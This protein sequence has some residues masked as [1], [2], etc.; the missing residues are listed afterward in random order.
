MARG[1]I[2]LS[3]EIIHGFTSSLLMRNFDSPQP[4]PHCHLEW[5]DL[6]CQPERKVA[7]AAP[8][9]HAK[10]TAITHSFTLASLLFRFRDHAMIVSDTEEQACAFLG[11]MKMELEENEELR[12][13]FGVVRFLKDKES[14]V[15]VLM[16]D[17]HQFRIIARG[18]NQKLRGL[19]WRHKRP[20][21]IIGDDLEND[22][23]V[24]NQ[25][26]R[27]KFHNWFLKALM[28][29]GSDD[30]IFR[31]VGTILHLDSMLER[32]MPPIGKPSTIDEGLRSISTDRRKVWKSYRYKA[33]TDDFSQ[34]LW[35]EKFPQERLEHER[36]DYID[37]G[38]PEGY[39]QE[40]L[41]YPI[42]DS[43]AYFRKDDFRFEFDFKEVSG[44]PLNYYT[45]IDFAISQQE[46]AD[47]TAI[48]TVAVDS[49]NVMYVVD[50]RKGR[51][52]SMEIIEEMFNVHLAYKPELFI[53]ENGTIEKTLG[54]FLKREMLARGIFLNL[55]R[56]TPTKDKLSRARS[57]Q[58]RIRQG[59]IR[60]DKEFEWYLD[61]ENELKTFPRG[62]HDDYV[63]A[64]AWI[65]LTLA[66]INEAPTRQEYEDEA[67]EE[68]FGPLMIHYNG[69]SRTTGY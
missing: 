23:M 37:Q 41:N 30:A 7:I 42:D 4:T 69:R 12:N 49:D 15:I 60:F 32:L 20:N 29:A 55:Y 13:L 63:D 24:M 17:S 45:A 57:I 66:S 46:R 26:R 5:W 61:F 8:R 54:P 25:E 35:P 36:Q 1:T 43:T 31:I 65:G 34:I 3:A 39:S 2:Q 48:V 16:S 67:Y 21:L 14:E 51:W 56:V 38:Y 44:K 62:A 9:G 52:D 19:K 33:H 59:G 11:D 40:Y 64:F 47:Y 22:E 27:Q 58:A 53:A 6:V 68:E 50:A 10:S 18:S 28:P